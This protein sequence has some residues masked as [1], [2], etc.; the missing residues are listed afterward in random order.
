MHADALPGQTR[1]FLTAPNFATIA[2]LDPDGAPRQAVVWFTLDGDDIIINSA[3][4]RRW[5]ANLVRDPRIAI[6]VTDRVDGY[7]WVGLSGSVTIIRDQATS[8]ADI[9][10]M[11]RR[12]HA[13]DPQK[14]EALIS[15]RFQG[16]ERISFRLT[17]GSFHDHLD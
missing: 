12:Y 15:A 17:I 2:T 13:D 4:G 5:P 6:S 8:Q 16:Q 3:V 11:A 9:A 1:A 14:A 10:A 7:R